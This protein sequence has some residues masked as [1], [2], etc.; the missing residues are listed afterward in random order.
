MDDEQ[1]LHHLQLSEEDSAQFV[2][3]SLATARR[4]AAR[5]YYRRPYGNEED[6][7]SQIITS[8]VQDSI[9]W[10]L[11]DLLDV[12]ITSEDAVVFDPTR[13][14][15][16]EG[17]KQATDACNY[18]FYKQNNGFLVLQ[19]AFK[20]ALMSRNCA[21]HWRKETVRSKET[22]PVRNASLEQ[23][24]LQMQE[25][26]EKAELLDVEELQQPLIDPTTGQ[27]FVDELGQPMLQTII[28]AKI[29][30]IAERKK[31]TVDAFEPENLLV[32]RDWTSPLL[33]D[34][35]YVARLMPVML[36]D[37]KA[38]GFDDVTAEELAASGDPAGAGDAMD[39]NDRKGGAS[40]EESYLEAPVLD[41]D[42]ES[43]TTGWLR[44]E[45]VLVDFDGDGIAERREIY[46]LKDRVLSNEE[47]SQVPVATV[48]PILV[49]HRWDGLS[50]AE[51]VSDIQL[52]NTELTRG[53][54]NNAYLAN[55]PRKTVLLDSNGAPLAS[56]DDLLDGRPGGVVQQKRADAIGVELTPFVGN[57][58]FPLL[59]HVR[60]MREERTGLTKQRMGMD[61]NVLRS[62]RTLGETQIIDTASKQRTKLVAR[63]FGELL[64]APIFKGILR[65]LTE[66]DMDPLFFKLRGKFVELNPNEWRDGYD[67]TVNV[68]LGTG[69]KENVIGALNNVRQT[70]MQLAP[71]PLGPSMVTPKQI[72]NTNVAI[73]K[74]AGIQN[75]GEF[76]TDP[77]DA[78][79]PTPPPPPPDP[80]LQIAQ[81][82]AQSQQQIEGIK[83]NF[84]AQNKQAEREQEA[85]IER[86]RMQMQAEV[87]N[88]RQRSEAE[89]HALKIQNEAQLEQLKAQYENK[90]HQREMAFK[91]WMFEQEQAQAR[92]KAELDAATK[93]EAANISSKS[94][95]DNAATAAATGEIAAEVQQ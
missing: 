56:I 74:I 62:D 6:G 50:I 48:S 90:R 42:D 88:N 29:T 5:E 92:W 16:V 78:K 49:Q 13:E 10:M 34:C 83:L 26:G 65:L 94:K 18:V 69:D 67:M 81:I 20:D 31:I 76:F 8:D 45:W 22:I 15:E 47:C 21:V 19:T 17:A 53:I 44:I 58:M 52:L 80:Q 60:S 87:D 28:N 4:K 57:Q 33:E 64:V 86:M 77:G 25:A 38:M 73:L 51:V 14:S 35:P 66:G 91:Q 85:A 2:F 7:W 63:N 54:V 40:E 12:F 70:Q 61:P 75:V 84:E 95:L 79:M 9:E 30:R 39:A 55:N 43:L 24:A 93:I 1:L 41:S 72:Y 59:E 23:L 71:S 37:L 68:G 36:S 3:G 82:R 32:K 11:P 27:P 89:Q 46:R